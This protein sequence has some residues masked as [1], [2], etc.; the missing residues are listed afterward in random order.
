MSRI[1]GNPPAPVNS[2]VHIVGLYND[3]AILD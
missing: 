3:P 2:A 1:P